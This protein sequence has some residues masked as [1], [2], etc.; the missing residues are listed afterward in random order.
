MGLWLQNARYLLDPFRA[1]LRHDKQAAAFATATEL[2]RPGSYSEEEKNFFIFW[3]TEKRPYV[4]HDIFPNR[5]FAALNI[6]GSVGKNL[7]PRA[8]KLDKLC[9]DRYMPT[10]G[11]L[12]SV[13]DH[14]H[15]GTNTLS[16][17]LC[18]RGE[19]TPDSSNTFIMHV[20]QRKIIYKA[21]SQYE[22]YTILFK[23]DAPFTIHAISQEP[24]W[25]RG[26]TQE[27]NPATH[28]VSLEDL[29][30]GQDDFLYVTSMSWK[31]VEQ[32]YHGYLDDVVLL[33][34]GVHDGQSGAADFEA[35][36]LLQ[37]VAYC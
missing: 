17:T 3:D 22:P 25:I 27:R 4:H 7:A 1:R 24:L 30:H 11:S 9:M 2:Q 36:H 14:V 13:K 31:S 23:G 19:C 16:I 35:R 20:F 10:L 33:S 18:N 5:V 26:R 6:D 12:G 32:R 29:K 15:Q 8:A 34:F 21:Y 28:D 37:S